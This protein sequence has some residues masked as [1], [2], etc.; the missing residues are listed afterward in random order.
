[1][2]GHHRLLRARPAPDPGQYAKTVRRRA[3]PRG[4]PPTHLPLRVNTA[5]VIPPIFA[6]SLLMFPQTMAGLFIRP[7]SVQSVQDDC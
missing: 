5:G 1:V 4:G 7:G 2:I 3:R 6:S